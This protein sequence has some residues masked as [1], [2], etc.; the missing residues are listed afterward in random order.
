M[1]VTR[2]KR[3]SY[4]EATRAWADSFGTCWR[5]GFRGLWQVSLWIHHFVSGSSRQKDNLYTTAIT[6]ARC[7]E[8]EHCGKGIGLLGWIALKRRRDPEWYS[9][10]EVCKAKG[11]AETAITEDEIDEADSGLNG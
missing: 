2:P 3:A 6:C 5:C 4:S 8:D 11:W 10:A 9:L 7:H 1:S